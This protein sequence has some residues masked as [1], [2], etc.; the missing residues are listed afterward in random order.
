[1]VI[2]RTP[3]SHNPSLFSERVVTVHVGPSQTTWR[4]HENLLSSSS[5]FFRSAFN[6]GFLESHEDKLLLPE[7]DPA[8]FEL[9]VRW[10]YGRAIVS[11]PPA[12]AA[13]GSGSAGGGGGARSQQASATSLLFQALAPPPIQTWLRLYALACKLMVEELENICAGAAWRYYSVG[14]RRPD[15]RDVQ[16]IYE[17]TPPGCGM[18]RLLRER[19]TMGMFRGRQNNPVTEEWR[20][21]FNETPDL[22][23]D[24]VSEISGFHWIIGNNAPAR[25]AS[26]E[27]AF[28]RHEKG[29]V[30]R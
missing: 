30:C 9:F 2:K 13:S 7:D 6:S 16:Y 21:V 25:P 17:N 29:E 4:L 28:H 20:D 27:C 18:R 11:P 24:I 5:D 15:V 12:S 22:G 1:M 3:S 26:E 14:T 8:A 19:L 10:L 23:F